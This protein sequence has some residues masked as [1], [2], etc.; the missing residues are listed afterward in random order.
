MQLAACAVVLGGAPPVDRSDWILSVDMADLTKRKRDEEPTL[1]VIRAGFISES[2]KF[3]GGFEDEHAKRKQRA[4]DEGTRFGLT[5]SPTPDEEVPSPVESQLQNEYQKDI[6]ALSV[7]FGPDLETYHVSVVNVEEQ[8]SRSP[9]EWQVVRDKEAKENEQRKADAMH[10]LE[11]D[12]ARNRR[13]LKDEIDG[14]QKILNLAEQKLTAEKAKCKRE[15]PDVAFKSS[16]WYLGFLLAIGLSEFPMN[17]F[18]FAV[19]G[20]NRILT[21]LMALSLVVAIPLASHFGGL[22]LK[23]RREE[24]INLG[25]FVGLTLGI[26]ALAYFMGELREDYM[27]QV[28]GEFTALSK[29][30]FVVLNVLLYGLG[31]LLAFAHHDSSRGFEQAWKTWEG[32]KSTFDEKSPRVKEELQDELDRYGSTRG[33]I[34]AA[35]QARI[36]EI[37]DLESNVGIALRDAKASY[38]SCLKVLKGIEDVICSSYQGSVNAFR[39]SNLANRENHRLPMSFKVDPRPLKKEFAKYRELDPNLT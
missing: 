18:V 6:G 27:E 33:K 25:I 10:E 30:L 9:E 23:R 35:Y 12:H 17:Q 4:T 39:S 24:A 26:G 11:E 29:Y 3:Q 34:E 1:P 7:R 2:K 20:E 28:S 8:Q 36:L 16:K 14:E 32:V 38:D 5:N 37:G 21:I 22:Y 19:A 15:Y 31:V 13:Q